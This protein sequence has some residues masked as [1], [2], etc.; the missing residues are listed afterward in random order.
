MQGR[1][2]CR[3][4]R[5]FYLEGEQLAS[6]SRNVHIGCGFCVLKHTQKNADIGGGKE[7]RAGGREAGG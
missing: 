4:V 5:V 3:D 6:D 1:V 2:P 7:Q